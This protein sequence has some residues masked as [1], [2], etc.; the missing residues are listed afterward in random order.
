[1]PYRESGGFF[2]V[3]D[4]LRAEVHE[5]AMFRLFASVLLAAPIL[6]AAVSGEAV[7]NTHCASCHDR[8]TF[9]KMP[10]A[11][12]LQALESGVMSAVAPLAKDERE[13]VAAYLGSSSASN[14]RPEAFC[15]DRKVS[16][17]SSA[18]LAWN[19][20]SPS[21]G[22]TRYQP[23]EAAGLTVEQVRNL[24]LKWAFGFE[25][26]LT[27]FSQPA[28][29]DGQVF[30]GS[31]AGIVYA[32]R[33]DSGCILWT[34]QGIGPIRTAIVIASRG[35]GHAVLFGDQ[36]AS[37]YAV[38]AETGKLLWKK[39]VDEHPA[40][41][42]TG[43]P[44]IHEGVV[45]VPVSSWEE[46]FA[47]QADYR[48]C[49]FRGS[50]VALRVRDGSQVW[51]TYTVSETPKPK[52]KGAGPSG[53]AVWS[54]PTVDAKR[55]LLYITTG[56]NYSE[57]ATNL[58][59]SVVAMNLATGRVVWSRQVTPKDIFS[60][61]TACMA[62]LGDEKG[63]DYDFGSSAM[64]VKAGNRELIVAGKKS[65]VVWA[66]D[67]DRKGEVVWQTR[68]AKGSS[69]GGVQW[70][71]ASDG[72]NVYAPIADGGLV[73]IP[74]ADGSTQRLLDPNDGGGLAALRLTDGSVAWKAAPARVCAGVPGCSPSQLA[75]ATAIPGVVFS[76]AMDGHI[77]AYS[78]EDGKV[79]WDFNTLREFPTVNGVKA[80]G[81]ALNGSGPV[82]VNG[83]VLVNS[84]YDH[85]G[86]LTGNVLLAFGP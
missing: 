5:D 80:N 25:G 11:R 71:T 84:G 68:V 86:S 40:A 14:L 79:I 62:E 61:C 81:G 73:R 59:D 76:G 1:L 56:N 66:L 34:F 53:V 55:G 83:M 3:I 52:G 57:P 30:A 43:S 51:K 69:H 9:K 45:F 22:N 78:A 44:A 48:C 85:F 24:K 31:S 6:S 70:G 38:D 47:T 72:Q 18:K 8:E 26:E 46:N 63:P 20:W 13:A 12:I 29:L 32:L 41:R 17:G 58:S 64:L 82:V 67:P 36:A 54:T 21:P 77:R 75:A 10:S 49:T 50:V 23:G 42:V 65:G 37:F 19:G 7:Y 27:S 2:V 15:R 35:V 28:V 60:G 4:S 39:K 74:S 16:I 33:A